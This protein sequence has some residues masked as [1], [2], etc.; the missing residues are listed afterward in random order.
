MDSLYSNLGLLQGDL[1]FLKRL[2]VFGDL[3]SVL[4]QKPIDFGNL[5]SHS[6]VL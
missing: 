5:N 3:E 6:L 4:S 2:V 1:A